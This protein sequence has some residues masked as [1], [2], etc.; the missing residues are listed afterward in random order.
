MAGGDADA[1]LLVVDGVVVDDLE[2]GDGEIADALH[3]DDGELAQE[4]SPLPE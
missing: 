2:N 3:A 4:E 1:G